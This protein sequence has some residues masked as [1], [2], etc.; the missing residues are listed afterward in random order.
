MAETQFLSIGLY[1]YPPSAFWTAA[2]GAAPTTAII[3]ANV[4]SGPGTGTE[5]NFA[6]I[7]AEAA[8][9]GI[10]LLGYI[11]TDY[12]SASE[13]SVEAQVADWY[14]F[15]PG[16]IGGIFFDEVEATTGNE[17][18]YTALVDYIHTNH[19]GSTVMLNP[20]VI[21]AEA[22]LSTPIG[23]IIQVEENTYANYLGDAA[24]APS[25]LF[26]YPSSQFAVTV[27]T[28]TTEADMA[29]AIALSASAFNAKYVWITADNIYNALPSYFSAEV[30]LLQPGPTGDLTVTATQ[31]GSTNPGILLRVRVLD[32]AAVAGTPNAG[33]QSGADAHSVTITTTEAGSYVYGA[34]I[35]GDDATV[36]MNTGCTD[37]DNVV[38]ATNDLCYATFFSG[39]TGTPGANSVGTDASFAGGVAALEVIP[40][41]GDIGTDGSSPAVVSSITATTIESASFTP[42]LGTLLIAMAAT[43][44][45]F[46]DVTTMTVADS[47]GLSWTAAAQAHAAS[48]FY[49]GIWFAYAPAV[50]TI[51]TA[52][53]PGAT[54]GDSYSQTV[55]GSGGY[56]ACTWSVSSGS[57][58]A[59]LSLA[60]ATG[61]I[62]GT[63]TALGTSDFTIRVTDAFG[64]TASEP[65]SI[66]VSGTGTEGAYTALYTPLYSGGGSG[67]SGGDIVNSWAGSF[68]RPLA[69]VVPSLS[70]LA[71]PLDAT[72]SEGPGDG[73]PAGAG[74]WMFAIVAWRQDAGTAGV[75]QYPS[76][77]RIRDDAHNW[78]LPVNV[79]PPQ[80]GIVRCSVWMAPAFRVPQFVFASPTAYQSAL[81]VSIFEVTAQVAWYEVAA[82]ANAYTNQGA[83]VTQSQ[84]PASGLFSFGVLAWDL[85]DLTVT[86]TDAGWTSQ[87]SVIASNGSDH[88]GDLTMASF[89]ATT[90]GSSMALAASGT[91]GNADWAE[92]LIVVHGVT[93]AI[94][95][96]YQSTSQISNWPALITEMACGEVL[97][98]NASLN[99]GTGP[100]T[101]ANEATIAASD[102]FT[103]GNSAGSMLVTPGGSFGDQG[104]ASES[105][106]VT[107][108]AEYA[109]TAQVTV[110][111]AWDGSV[112]G[113]ALWFNS[114]DSL[115]SQSSTPTYAVTGS[116]QQLSATVYAPASAATCLY[117]VYLT[118]GTVPTTAQMYVGYASFAVPGAHGA[119]PDDQLN[120]I[121][122]SGRNFTKEP[123]RISRSI[124]YE[125]QSLEAGTLELPLA[126][127]DGFLT[128]GNQQSPY[129]PY[130]GDDDVPIRVRAVWP[131][132]VTPYSVL[133]SGFTDD[134]KIVL[135]EETLYQYAQVTAADC[136]SRLTAQMLTAAQQEVLADIPAG[137]TGGF[138]PCSD[139]SGAL[140]ASNL[141]PTTTPPLAV[142]VSKFGNAGTSGGFGDTSI[143]LLGDP[144]GT[145]WRLSG[146]SSTTGVT[147]GTSLTLFP[148][149]PSVLPPIA[150]GVSVEAWVFLDDEAAS[151]TWNGSIMA[152]AGAKGLVWQFAIGAP[153]GGDNGELLFITYDKTTGDATVTVVDPGLNWGLTALYTVE[154]TQTTWAVYTDGVLLDSGPADFAAVYS[155]FSFNGLNL[156]YAGWSGYCVNATMQ[157]IAVSPLTLPQPR[158]IAHY[159]VAFN[160]ELDEADT[161]RLARVTGYGGFVPPL[162]MFP[163]GVWPNVGVDPVTQITDTIGQVVSDY[164]TNVAS[165]TLAMLC[166]DGTGAMVYRQRAQWYDR[167]IGT[168]T[169]GEQAPL[170]LNVNPDFSSGV[171]SW[172]A[173]GATLTWFVN[174]GQ[175]YESGAAH[176]LA[177]GASEVT[178]TPENQPATPGETCQVVISVLSEAGYLAGAFAEIT[179]LNSSA[180]SISSASGNTVPLVEGGWT[181]LFVTAQAPAGTAFISPNFYTYGT[182]SEGAVFVVDSV[183]TTVYPGEAPYLRDVRTSID[184]AQMFNTAILTQSGTGELTTFSGST[185]NFSPTS[186]ITVSAE[187]E[188]SVAERGAVPYTATLYLQNTAQSIPQVAPFSDEPPGTGFV[189]AEGS[190]ED[191]GS[192]IVQ[193]LGAPVLRGDQVTLTPAATWQAMVT[194]LQAEIGDTVTLNRRPI[195]APALSLSNYLSSLSHEINIADEES[196]WVTTYQVSPA[197][198]Q[199]VLQ[200]DSP[201]W[202]CLTGQSL[203]GW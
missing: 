116:A 65:Y 56:T 19:A 34:I 176:L 183:I 30:A 91:G 26:D 9:A 64:N 28:C 33:E 40:S 3:I 45:N 113:V 46:G 138:W 123:T 13:A 174:G 161:S 190:M 49:A 137:S 51:T 186:G 61:V 193:T 180:S 85:N 17:T 15:Y 129:Y 144:G 73:T 139:N 127:N 195:G 153:T 99:A 107:P 125:Q 106:E 52:S 119:V 53:L 154:F 6:D 149:D 130:A 62:S 16:V 59:G 196:P 11:S 136:W 77:V 60:A 156:P 159:N 87:G 100:W 179:W 39:P 162:A 102:L 184:R 7:Y 41:G 200:C 75:L 35:D 68:S 110:P 201:V 202:G 170:A 118:G 117:E 152:C 115:I 31:G 74:N 135:D 111:S 158:L 81:T 78:W 171:E 112:A 199:Q 148:P 103:F 132:S 178:L 5:T 92:V 2:I 42:P 90:T 189:P 203:L 101:G 93:D 79:V 38:D 27:N 94:A 134:I 177:S 47:Y 98:Q 124:Q 145:G 140:A 37:L 12:G 89:T 43:G 165:S 160:A 166:V 164:W 24:D 175:F 146:M 182:P 71:I 80:T 191:F 131:N 69:S 128:Q 157:N 55:E 120:W 109:L 4:D 141:A 18:Y 72:T 96:P 168:W 70:P 187:N 83:S 163:G 198:S 36:P 20:G 67:P 97:N 155:G 48:N 194:A 8:A 147:K 86:L 188:A 185:L 84:D 1:S 88:T 57:L 76:S 29:N 82:Y 105:I 133:Y 126:N 63:P 14:S 169:L 108:F 167:A 58:P 142:Q 25:F 143:S 172:T 150:D 192:W 21:P 151:I 23:D 122:L 114:S 104:C 54:K 32:N 173:T 50:L 44:G 10:L 66:V 181:R 121:D 197:P 22:Y 95:Y